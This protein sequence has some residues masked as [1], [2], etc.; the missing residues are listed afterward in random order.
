[1]AYQV[2]AINFT[3]NK[4]INKDCTKN[5]FDIVCFKNYLFFLNFIDTTHIPFSYE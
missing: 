4:V 5:R 2:G 1:M 3:S